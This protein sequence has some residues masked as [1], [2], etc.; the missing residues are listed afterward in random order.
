MKE[1]DVR[2]VAFSPDGKTLA[3]GYGGVGGGG[4]GVVLWDVAGAAAAG[5]RARSP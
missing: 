3:A 5:G 1:G 4:G 2:S